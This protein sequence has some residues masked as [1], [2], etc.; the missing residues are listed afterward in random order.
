M[1]R[2]ACPAWAW[3]R[4]SPHSDCPTSRARKLSLEDFRGRKVLLVYW[5]P[6]CGFCDILAPDLVRL[7]PELRARGVEILIVAHGDA[8]AE[9]RAGRGARAGG[10]D[11]PAAEGPLRV[12]RG[13]RLAGA[14][15]RRICW[16]GGPR[17]LAARRGL[18]RGDGYGRVGR[19]AGSPAKE[20]PG[21]ARSEHQQTRPRRDQGGHRRTTF[22]LP[23]IRG[24]TVSLEE[25]RGRR[26]L[27]VFTDPNCGPCDELAPYWSACTSRAATAT[28]PSSWSAA[29]TPRRTAARP[30]PRGSSS[31]C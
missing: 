1:T 25:Y 18:C 7:Q 16:T 24:G 2:G 6:Q 15:R 3:G 31:P 9:P 19:R 5:S 22:E 20:A 12:D 14:R 17:R 23:E 8:E 4:P 11:P 30:R 26:V 21:R 29:A 10:P 28:R 13:L 27:L